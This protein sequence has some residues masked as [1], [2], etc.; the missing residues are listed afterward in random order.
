[1]T[2]LAHVLT[3]SGTMLRRNLRHAVRY[4]AM[5]TATIMTPVALLLLF[6]GVFGGALGA[7]LNEGRGGGDYID[8][9]APGIIL[10]A[11][12]SGCMSTSV[13]VCVDM[14]DGIIARFRTMPVA[15]ASLLTGHVAAGVIM[16][17]ISTLA[18]VG[19][20]LLMGFRTSA[21]A[22]EWLAAGGLLIALTFALSWVAV[23]MGLAAKTPEGASNTP[24]LIQFLPFLGSAIVPPDSMPGAMS[25][26]AEHQPFTPLNETLR[27]LLTGGPI[28]DDAAISLA[29]C[30]AFAVTGY[31]WSR[32]LFR[33]DPSR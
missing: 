33:R 19:A 7:G 13:A 30:A 12:T 23:A 16:T 15:R 24:M 10:M 9:I 11:V 8:Y 31:V 20:A 28:G 3:D 29:W 27:G 26:F 1:M 21:T 18:V 14:T 32:L 22:V 4:P 5:L 17:S 25:A 2:A 6:V